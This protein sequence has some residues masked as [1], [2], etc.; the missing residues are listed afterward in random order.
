[1]QAELREQSSTE[2]STAPAKGFRGRVLL[3]LAVLVFSYAYFYQGGGW[4]QNS[5]FDLVRAILDEHT[6]RIDAYQS[7]TE[8]KAFFQGHFYSDKAPG[9]VLF[10]LPFVAISRPALRAL[11][12]DPH[13]P[14]G[15]VAQSYIA[16]LFSSAIPM[17]LAACVLY[18]LVG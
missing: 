12:I 15:L 17:A 5:R 8:D 4:N 1:M 3:L 2:E 14:R 11:G 16:T 13:S 6:L 7:N 9:Q 10:A 18:W